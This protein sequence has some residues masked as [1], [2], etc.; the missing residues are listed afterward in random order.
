MSCV[1]PLRSIM[2]TCRLSIG[3][4]A[5]Q[6]DAWQGARDRCVDRADWRRKRSLD[7][8]KVFTCERTLLGHLILYLGMFCDEQQSRC[9][10][11]EAVARMKVQPCAA[12][13]IEPQHGICDRAVR[14][15]CRRMHE[16]PCGFVDD[17]EVVVLVHD[18]ERKTLGG[19]GADNRQ[20]IGYNVSRVQ[21]GPRGDGGHAVHREC[22]A[23]LDAFPEPR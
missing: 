1:R 15:L 11:V 16:L 9:I 5:A 22:S 23:V 12:R 7:Q 2:G 14:L 18:C 13:G 21:H 6:N 8:G 20:L 3:R 17:E 19:D 4:N 10:A